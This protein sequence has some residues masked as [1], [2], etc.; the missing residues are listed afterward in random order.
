MTT[1]KII[2]AATSLA[3]AASLALPVFAAEPTEGA[4]TVTTH[5]TLTPVAAKTACVGA[6]VNTR[7][8]A[9]S[10]AAATFG[11]S[12]TSMYSAR[13]V[14]L[15]AAYSQSTPSAVRTAV[16]AAWATFNTSAKT[17]RTAWSSSRKSAWTAYRTAAVACKAPEGTGD[18]SN[19][20]SEVVAS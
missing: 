16:K 10:T 14:A 6:A 18:G 19:S 7:E 1:Q 4:G 20:V 5:N 9:L 11:Q 17:A 2:L 15:Q 12:L 8:K 3:L 13:A